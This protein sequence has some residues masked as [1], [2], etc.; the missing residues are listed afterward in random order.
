MAGALSVPAAV[1]EPLDPAAEPGRVA[2][3]NGIVAPETLTLIGFLPY[4]SAKLRRAAQRVSTPGDSL[5]RS[6]TALRTAGLKWGADREAR[7]ALKR[8][9]ATLG[10]SAEVD[11]SGL[12]ARITGP[13]TTW[14]TLYG[15]APVVGA[16]LPISVSTYFP[17]AETADDSNPAL[18]QEVPQ[19][20]RGVLRGLIPESVDLIPLPDAAAAR[21]MPIEPAVEPLPVNEGTP[22]GPG[23][24]C[25]TEQQALFPDIDAGTGK[26]Y[27]PSQLHTPY[28]TSA[29]RA[30]GYDGAG[31]RLTIVGL[32][33]A[34]DVGTPEIAAACFEYTAPDITNIGATGL[35]DEPV[36]GILAGLLPD[37]ES[38]LDVQVSAPVIDQATGISFVQ[39]QEGQST[40]RAIVDGFTTA[41]ARTTP[42]A[43]S[44]SYGLCIPDL[45][46]SGDWHYA[47]FGDDLFALGAIVGISL[48][49]GA[50]DSGSSGCLHGGSS[51]A[52]A[53][54][55]WPGGSPW[56]TAAGGTRIVLGAGNE[57][58]NE[59]TWNDTPFGD[60][61]GFAAGGGGLSSYARPW[62]QGSITSG[63][64]RA[65][66][67]LAVHASELVGWPVFGR[68]FPGFDDTVILFPEGGT[69]AASP[70]TAANVAL[71]SA[72]ERSRGRPPLG[73]INP[74]LYS[75]AGGKEYGAAFYDVVEG[76]NQ[77]AS[78]AGCC[79]ASAGFDLATGIGAPNFDELARLV[80]RPGKRAG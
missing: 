54:A 61:D 8:T 17:S 9:A 44:L 2:A 53:V 18:A 63:D 55:V 72:H 15:R 65:F 62:Y 45:E 3:A 34:Y 28:G 23:Q 66:P 16:A 40:V 42:D 11:P 50:G 31:A 24:E 59:V 70:F 80:P 47:R 75:V 10:L 29:L 39:A 49:T 12:V 7:R 52:A 58:V 46:K 57:R 43:L 36:P 33:Q 20:L 41:Y 13:T 74:W 30:R 1:A 79:R 48:F 77:V 73:F 69:S 68:L 71:I 4:D 60:P 51:D 6:F 5:Y 22:Y 76:T 38:D 37:S 25:V 64:R 78:S 19:A 21:S 14:Q 27:S 26:I 56:I 67:D 32:G 35:P